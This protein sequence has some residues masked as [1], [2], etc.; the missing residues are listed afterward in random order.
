MWISLERERDGVA[1]LPLC[2]F[3]GSGAT[4]VDV[5]GWHAEVPVC[6]LIVVEQLHSQHTHKRTAL[7]L[8]QLS[9]GVPVVPGDPGHRR[10]PEVH[11]VMVSPGALLVSGQMPLS[12]G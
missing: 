3:A 6:C 2:F 5:Q 7:K 10:A 1:A 11:P 4:A 9:K 12:I 8:P